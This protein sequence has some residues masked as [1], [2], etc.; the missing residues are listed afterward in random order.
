MEMNEA[1]TGIFGF[2]DAV[3]GNLATGAVDS[4]EYTA[5]DGDE[6]QD[7]QDALEEDGIWTKQVGDEILTIEAP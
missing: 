7:I 1:N 3:L 2:Y 4:V 5:V 6:D